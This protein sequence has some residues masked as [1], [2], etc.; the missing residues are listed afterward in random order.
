MRRS[1]LVLFL[2]LVLAARGFSQRSGA[3]GS[4]GAD[5]RVQVTFTDDHPANLQLKVELV[6]SS[7]EIQLNTA[8]TDDNGLCTFSGV[9]PGNYRV[10]V[11]GI[12]VRDAVGRVFS[13]SRGQ[14]I[15]RAHV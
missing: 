7:S 15:G 9:Q 5:V 4:G 12:G 13:I 6:T 1:T 14:E 10:R 2:L 3:T 8:F 11:S